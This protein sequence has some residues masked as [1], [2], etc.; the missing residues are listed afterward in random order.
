MHPKLGTANEIFDYRAGT[1]KDHF[2]K[3]ANT[4]TMHKD[5]VIT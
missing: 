4:Q 1:V 2:K 5:A 3:D